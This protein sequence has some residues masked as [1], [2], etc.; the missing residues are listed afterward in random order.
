ML[1]GGH[2]YYKVQWMGKWRYLAG[3]LPALFFV[4]QYLYVC[5]CMMVAADTGGFCSPTAN[6]LSRIQVPQ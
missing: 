3:L 6:T 4:S 2:Y 5:V 1:T